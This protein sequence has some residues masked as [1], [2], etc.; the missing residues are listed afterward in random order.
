M[1]AACGIRPIAY[2]F[3]QPLYLPFSGFQLSGIFLGC[4]FPYYL[5]D[6]RVFDD[7]GAIARIPAEALIDEE[8][9][10]S[11]DRTVRSGYFYV[12]ADFETVGTKGPQGLNWLAYK[13]KE[14]IVW[15]GQDSTVTPP[16]YAHGREEINC[17]YMDGHVA[18]MPSPAGSPH[19]WIVTP[20]Q[21]LK[22][23]ENL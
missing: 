19:A 21:T 16:R 20:T 4:I 9:G 13:T 22:V 23:S 5:E 6:E 18:P 7:P 12:N 17:L 8:L 11:Q 2:Y 15:C 3:F 1:P 14:P 10:R